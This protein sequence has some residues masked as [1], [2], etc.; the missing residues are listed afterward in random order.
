MLTAALLDQGDGARAAPRRSPSTIDS[1]GGA[2]G[3]GAGTE[4]TFVNTVVMKDGL[5]FALDLMAD[6]VRARRS[7]RR[8][9][10][11]SGSRRCRR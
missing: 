5:R 10:T 9:S 7:R 1:I 3:T 6:V 8:R 2:L 4:L 11:A